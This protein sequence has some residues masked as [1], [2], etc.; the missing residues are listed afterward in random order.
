[1]PYLYVYA[2]T[3][4]LLIPSTSKDLLWKRW[5]K[6]NS[7]NEGRHMGIKKFSNWLTEMQLKLIDKQGKPSISEEVKRRKFLN[8]PPQYMEGTLIP[9]IQEDW[10][11]EYLVQQVECYEALKRH[12]TVP[13]TR[14]HT[15]RPT[16]TETHNP[17]HNR[18]RN[19][20]QEQKTGFNP[21]NN[22]PSNRPTK[23]HPSNNPNWNTITRNLN[24][25]TKVEL[26]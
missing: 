3:A 6:A 5:E 24:Q 26:I 8:H 17:N 2:S 12:N 7:Y 1:M 10:T 11:Y 4:R 23:S 13:I 21:S 15:I 18:L 9:Q 20:R 22:N 16:S 25:K 19:R 14:M